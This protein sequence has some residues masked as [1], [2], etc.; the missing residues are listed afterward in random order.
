MRRQP[1]ISLSFFMINGGAAGWSALISHFVIRQS[2]NSIRDLY[3]EQYYILQDRYTAN[4][5]PCIG[6]RLAAVKNENK[7][8]AAE[9]Q[10]HSDQGFQYTSQAYF[11]LTQ[12]YSTTSSMSRRGNCYNNAMAE[13]F[14]PIRKT[15]CIHQYKPKTPKRPRNANDFIY[16]SNHQRIRLKTGVPPL[17][18]RHSI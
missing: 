3:D 14:F 12:R 15:E 17:T 9:L 4:R 5:K 10:L 2:F 16:F 13:T 8:V 6:Y 11:E 7:I 18:L 1:S